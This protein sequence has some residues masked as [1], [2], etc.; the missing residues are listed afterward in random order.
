MPSSTSTTGTSSRTTSSINA[1][2]AQSTSDSSSTYSST[3]LLK[4]TKTKSK[5]NVKGGS[6]KS[7]TGSRPL[8]HISWQSGLAE[9]TSWS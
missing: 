7:S 1:N 4:D 9:S 8:V 2:D 6:E 3:W 5:K